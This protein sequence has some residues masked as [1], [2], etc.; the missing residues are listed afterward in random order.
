MQRNVISQS[1]G[2]V[3]GL[4]QSL[5]LPWLWKAWNEQGTFQQPAQFCR[6]SQGVSAGTGEGQRL[7][8]L[9]NPSVLQSELWHSPE[10]SRTV[11]HST[12]KT[13]PT[14]ACALDCCS[15]VNSRDSICEQGGRSMG[16][17]GYKVRRNAMRVVTS[18]CPGLCCFC[19]GSPADRSVC[20]GRSV[21]QLSRPWL[22]MYETAMVGEIVWELLAAGSGQKVQEMELLL[23]LRC[24]PFQTDGRKAASLS[25]VYSRYVQQTFRTVN[26]GDYC[27]DYPAETGASLTLWTDSV[28]ASMSLGGDTA[29]L[30]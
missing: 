16:Y 13:L 17:F 1:H 26:R 2:Q 29:H 23:C 18:C 9:R 27:N 3:T 14:A 21:D 12:P 4:I 7:E 8:R 25:W 5:E 20:C 10:P 6:L 11:H 30:I 15:T 22:D 19:A 24:R 28:R